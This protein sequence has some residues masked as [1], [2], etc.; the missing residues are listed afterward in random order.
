MP[1]VVIAGISTRAAAESAARAGFDVTAIDFFAD[2]DQHPRVRAFSLPRDFGMAATPEHAACAAASVAADA[3]VY[4]SSFE[5]H[6]RAVSALASG[7]A[8][9]ARRRALWGN[10]P[11]TLARVRDPV[12]LANAL[13][14]RGCATPRVRRAGDST[15]GEHS[16]EWLLKP[17]RSGGGHGIRPWQPGMRVPADCYLQERIEGVPGS[18]VFVAAAGRARALA[19]TRQLIGG[20]GCGADGFR[21]CGNVLAPGPFADERDLFEAACEL[22]AVIADE[23]GL[24]GVNG[25]DF[26]ARGGAPYAIEVN[27]RWTG[28]V[29][30]VER[31][32][33]VSVFGMHAEACSSGA[34]PGVDVAAARHTGGAVG[35]MIVFAPRDACVGDTR[36]WLEDRDIRDVPHPGEHFTAGA[37]VCTVFANGTSSASC[38]QTLLERADRIRAA[39]KPI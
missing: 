36:A 38:Y 39:L 17:L 37:P 26:I 16:H 13:R 7:S 29:E 5:N 19:V 33:G 12:L 3:V 2:L 11:E 27:P 34:L 21:Y 24:V 6:P 28:A 8:G 9:D 32:Y 20:H 4:L 23:F 35:K 1:H 14:R 25:I 18:I 10:T 30:V 15:T 22:A 31:A